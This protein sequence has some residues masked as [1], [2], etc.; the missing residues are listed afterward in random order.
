MHWKKI[1]EKAHRRGILKNVFTSLRPT[2]FGQLY[3]RGI[4]L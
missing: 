4:P 3:V 1:F 2:K